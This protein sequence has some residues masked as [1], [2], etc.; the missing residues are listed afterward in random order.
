VAVLTVGRLL[1]W[2]DYP[3]RDVQAAIRAADLGVPVTFVRG[4]NLAFANKP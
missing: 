2:H 3:W 1:V 4:T